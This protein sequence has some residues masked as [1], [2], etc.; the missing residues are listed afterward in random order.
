MKVPA[1]VGETLVAQVLRDGPRWFGARVRG[2][3][4]LEFA[5]AAY[6]SGHSQIRHRY[7]SNSQS[8]P[9]PLFPEKHLSN[10]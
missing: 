4:P 3:I 9:A 7:R 1:L 10:C 8:E 2:F 6:R 5:G